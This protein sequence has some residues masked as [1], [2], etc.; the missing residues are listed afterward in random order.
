[1]GPKPKV[2]MVFSSLHAH[3]PMIT[4]CTL[5]NDAKDLHEVE[6]LKS[7]IDRDPFVG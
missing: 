1:M 3:V 4:I 7:Q 2:P 6:H 5:M